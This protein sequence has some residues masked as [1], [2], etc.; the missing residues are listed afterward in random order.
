M[1]TIQSYT[2]TWD[3]VKSAC[4]RYLDLQ[5]GHWRLSIHAHVETSPSEDT[6]MQFPC[7]IQLDRLTLDR[8]DPDQPFAVEAAVV[9]STG[10]DARRA[11]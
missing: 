8:V 9:N 6:A 7:S 5:E 1:S 10:L 4:I 3:E 11:S 2:L